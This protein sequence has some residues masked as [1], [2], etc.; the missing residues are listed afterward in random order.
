VNNSR[1]RTRVRDLHREWMKDPEYR[2]A[3]DALEDEFAIAKALIE[4]R[5]AAGLTQD[6]VARRMKTS[7]SFIARLESGRVLPSTRTL[8]RYA[9]ATGHRLTFGFRPHGSVPR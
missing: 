7:R 5:S 8:K 9:T 4:A 2:K 6:Q 3:Y 1:K